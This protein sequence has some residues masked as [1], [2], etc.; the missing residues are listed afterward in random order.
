[1][2]MGTPRTTSTRRSAPATRQGVPTPSAGRPAARGW[3][4]PRR[5]GRS[6]R[7]LVVLLA[8]AALLIAASLANASPLRAYLGSKERLDAAQT[9]VSH[10][11]QETAQARKEVRALEDGIRVEVQARKDLTY[12]REGE[13]MFIIEGLPASSSTTS[14]TASAATASS[15]QGSGGAQGLLDRV[16]DFLAGLLH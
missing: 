12:A 14:S 8:L 5:R 3:G 7:G 16:L 13:E 1:M 2:N 15:G 6:H 9:E 10:L 4:A 11:E